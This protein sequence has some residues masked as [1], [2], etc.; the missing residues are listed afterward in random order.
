ML[1]TMKKG[2]SLLLSL[3]LLS[4][5]SCS[6]QGDAFR[7]GEGDGITKGAPK[8][9]AT[10]EPG[11]GSESPP[12]EEEG[13]RSDTDCLAG[14]LCQ[15]ST[16]LC[17]AV[18]CPGVTCGNGQSLD[19]ESCTCIQTCTA[20]FQA[21]LTL[22][23][24]SSADPYS[25]K[26]D[27]PADCQYY[28]KNADLYCCSQEKERFCPT[29][30]GPAC[31]GFQYH[32]YALAHC[33]DTPGQDKMNTLAYLSENGDPIRL[34]FDLSKPGECSVY[35]SAADFPTY[36]LA[37]SA[38][39][40]LLKIDMGGGQEEFKGMTAKGRCYEEG[41]KIHITDLKGSH[42]KVRF[43]DPVADANELNNLSFDP[44]SR[45]S[46]FPPQVIPAFTDD[47]KTPADD[48]AGLAFTTETVTAVGAPGYPVRAITITG[49][50]LEYD[51]AL[52][53]S[54][55][56]LVAGLTITPEDDSSLGGGKLATALAGASL[57][58]EL[59]GEL[60]NPETGNPVQ[61]LA[62]LKA[63]CA[64][65]TT[66]ATGD[67][68]LALSLVHRWESSGQ[69]EAGE[70]AIGLTGNPTDGYLATVIF[71]SK[72]YS[73]GL[74]TSGTARSARQLIWDQTHLLTPPAT[75]KRVVPGTSVTYV[76][77]PVAS[78]QPSIERQHPERFET[79][80]VLTISNQSRAAALK[81]D[82]AITP[83]DGAFQ[84][85]T[86]GLQATIPAKEFL[87]LPVKFKPGKGVAGC[88]SAGLH[89]E[90]QVQID[91]DRLVLRLIGEGRTPSAELVVSEIQYDDVYL[92]RVQTIPAPVNT[93]SYFGNLV[94]EETTLVGTCRPKIYRIANAGTVDLSIVDLPEYGS[95]TLF[96]RG[97]VAQGASF[98]EADGVCLN[99][100]AASCGSIPR[101]EAISPLGDSDIFYI[102]QYCPRSYSLAQGDTARYTFESSAGTFAYNIK[103][104]SDAKSEALLQLYVSDFEDYSG[105]RCAEAPKPADLI[106]PSPG[107]K[108]LYKVKDEQ[109]SFRASSTSRDVYAVNAKAKAGADK[110]RLENSG[111]L[112]SLP[113]DFDEGSG[114]FK[115]VRNSSLT[116]PVTLEP[117]TAGTGALSNECAVCSDNACKK[118]GTLQFNPAVGESFEVAQ[119]DFSVAF[120]SITA[121]GIST[122]MTPFVAHLKGANGVDKINGPK[123]AHIT[124]IF[125]G[126]NPKLST[127]V[128]LASSV[129]RGQARAAGVPESEWDRWVDKFA[130]PV[131]LDAAK[132]TVDFPAVYTPV[133]SDLTIRAPEG[134]SLF[135]TIGSAKDS[136]GEYLYSFQCVEDEGDPTSPAADNCRQFYI[137]IGNRN[138]L[139]RRPDGSYPFYPLYA[140]ID[141][142]DVRAMNPS[143]L[144]SIL[145]NP[146]SHFK[147][148]YD[149]IT[150]EVSIDN[151][152]ALRI[153][154]PD[155]TLLSG[156]DIDVTLESSLTTECITPEKVPQ[157]DGIYTASG[158]YPLGLDADMPMLSATVDTGVVNSGN[159]IASYGPNPFPLYVQ[160]GEGASDYG[161]A[162][163]SVHGRRLWAG[164][165][166]AH[167]GNLDQT[168]TLDKDRTHLS[169][170]SA[171]AADNRVSNPNFDLSAVGLMRANESRVHDK[172]MFLTIKL[173]LGAAGEE[174]GG[175][176]ACQ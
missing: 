95:K 20:D 94:S 135:N 7:F 22:T 97:V 75:G 18:Q 110:L 57:V 50:A 134:V 113:E 141:T 121:S 150:G 171:Y 49:R 164:A 158:A 30:A 81:L 87:S 21:T 59:E 98:R 55:L 77:L 71:E 115:F 137:Y 117:C 129:T 26:Y 3:F 51:P 106:G 132:G 17:L 159:Q 63:H 56:K 146:S 96:V 119:H 37:N 118:I 124:R 12:P 92:G 114:G 167:A 69:L 142:P 169:N 35:L 41:G 149:P 31:S 172:V 120:K 136:T 90:A 14:E 42:F 68:S 143:S 123:T 147:G 111:D 67:T 128:G 109:F 58:A 39:E 104:K 45:P 1:Q 151:D 6:G 70:D 107:N 86:E 112:T 76:P 79:S 173:C 130:I 65:E 46:A 170:P 78:S 23:G 102:L 4:L 91:R 2:T 139:E 10:D 29:E 89:C 61:S 43:Y 84:I 47:P 155:A 32:R 125:A 162:P 48:A 148:F 138:L 101:M 156:K 33:H 157:L 40:G 85:D 15:V 116:Y 83:A 8:A 52:N 60:S 122:L 126:F 19:L 163:G 103:G 140:G 62:D 88:D 168:G 105:A 127:S 28:E 66:V 161:C 34:K 9:P 100:S 174:P 64:S 166:P 53:Q 74:L 36:D 38:L 99:A 175:N 27:F 131:I 16:G 160:G 72:P 80:E 165:D 73:K 13:C 93:T 133:P 11:E 152:V 54:T 176:A 144:A 153:Y 5:L 82:I 108:C 25:E 145:G 154:S 44:F 24:D